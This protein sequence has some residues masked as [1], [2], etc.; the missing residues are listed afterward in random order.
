MYADMYPYIPSNLPDK[1]VIYGITFS[2]FLFPVFPH[3]FSNP[4]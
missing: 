2:Q 1:I 4:F 3:D